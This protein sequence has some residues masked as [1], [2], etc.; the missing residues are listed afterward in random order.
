MSTP[1]TVN[2]QPTQRMIPSRVRRAISR[3]V[4]VIAPL[5][6]YTQ[7]GEVI[8]VLDF[9]SHQTPGKL[10][11]HLDPSGTLLAQVFLS[12]EPGQVDISFEDISTIDLEQLSDTDVHFSECL[13]EMHLIASQSPSQFYR[14]DELEKLREENKQ[15][16][17]II[18]GC[19]RSGTTLLL[20]VLGSHPGVLAFPDEL[21]AFYPKP[22]RLRKLLDAIRDYGKGRNWQRWCEKTPK[23]VCV[24]GDIYNTFDGQAKLIHMV[25]DGRDVV[26]SHHPNDG[27]RYYVSPERWVADVSRGL[28]FAE[29]SL[30]VRYED[31]V[32]EPESVIRN[33]C[34]FIGEDFDMR[35][36]SHERYSTVQEN[37]AWENRRVVPLNR[38]SVGRWR[39]SENA[40]RVEEF[41]NFPG[42]AKLMQQ[43]KYE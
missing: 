43:L 42:A 20:S 9:S 41:L 3:K 4:E 30:L 10:Y 14:L 27:S 34:E 25:R 29:H 6:Y 12:E 38:E 23:N 2:H 13:L 17:I 24:F 40:A 7:Q 1:V 11:V 16:P 32:H 22:F 33:V 5:Q 35:M 18:G 8:Y 15:T 26:T 39:D 21:Y 31:M 28:S 36:L 19:G 37:K